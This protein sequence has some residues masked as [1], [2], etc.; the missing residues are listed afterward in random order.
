MPSCMF[1]PS[2]LDSRLGMALPQELPNW[3]NRAAPNGKPSLKRSASGRPK[4]QLALGGLGSTLNVRNW[5]EI[6]CDY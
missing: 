3:A 5:S 1:W 6:S 4:A 2:A